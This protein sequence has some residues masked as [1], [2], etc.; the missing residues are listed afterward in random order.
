ESLPSPK[1]LYSRLKILKKINRMNGMHS[2]IGETGYFFSAYCRQYDVPQNLK[3]YFESLRS[4]LQAKIQKLRNISVITLILMM[5][6]LN[7][8]DPQMGIPLALLQKISLGEPLTKI[9]LNSFEKHYAVMAKDLPACRAFLL[10]GSNPLCVQYDFARV[11]VREY[12]R[13]TVFSHPLTRSFINRL[14]DYL[15]CR[16]M[17]SRCK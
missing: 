2:L 8:M 4:T 6:R 16:V 10:P 12:E 13:K 7:K 3:Q 14:S 1:G 15:F 5:R 9:N 17:Q 11:K